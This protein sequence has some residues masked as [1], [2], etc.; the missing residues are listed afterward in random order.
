MTKK[1]FFLTL[2]IN[3]N[4]I[5]KT[6]HELPVFQAKVSSHSVM[7]YIDTWS[8]SS[9]YSMIEDEI[10]VERQANNLII[11]TFNALYDELDRCHLT[12][13]FD[14]SSKEGW[15]IIQNFSRN[16]QEA[17]PGNL[18]GTRDAGI[19]SGCPFPIPHPSPNSPPI[20]DSPLPVP[21][22]VG[23]VAEGVPAGVL[24]CPPLRTAE[25]FGTKSRGFHCASSA[26]K[27]FVPPWYG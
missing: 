7:P 25:S 4:V 20:P 14:R 9:A 15:N 24:S 23:G 22:E 12:S 5:S 3:F 16:L 26:A 6:W 18:R 27:G 2:F 1:I 19:A 17:Q 21:R 8:H 11:P 10:K 13:E